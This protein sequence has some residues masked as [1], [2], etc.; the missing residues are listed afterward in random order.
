M[1]CAQACPRQTCNP[2]I[3]REGTSLPGSSP[4]L[5][6]HCA[7]S[8][9]ADALSY[10]ERLSWHG[11]SVLTPGA[12]HCEGS[13]WESSTRLSACPG[14]TWARQTLGPRASEQLAL[15]AAHKGAPYLLKLMVTIFLDAEGDH[16]F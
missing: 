9:Q 7:C 3:L 10:R 12:W 15:E 6:A 5:V 13:A 1:S 11:H 16:F 8:R 2:A 14:P 4:P